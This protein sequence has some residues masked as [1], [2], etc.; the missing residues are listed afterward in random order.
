MNSLQRKSFDGFPS[1]NC[2]AVDP[3]LLDTESYEKREVV[4]LFQNGLRGH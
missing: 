4:I 1:K 2:Q 3:I